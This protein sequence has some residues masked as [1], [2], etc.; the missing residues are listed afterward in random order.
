MRCL[1]VAVDGF[2]KTDEILMAEKIHYLRDVP[3]HGNIVRFIGEVDDGGAEG[4]TSFI[5][6]ILYLSSSSNK[7]EQLET[8]CLRQ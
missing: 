6:V 8:A 1:G 5:S 4:I 3:P 2:S 7:Q